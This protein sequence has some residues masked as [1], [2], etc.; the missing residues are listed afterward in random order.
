MSTQ[1]EQIRA[2]VMFRQS[3]RDRNSVTFANACESISLAR[4]Q[5]WSTIS[6]AVDHEARSLFLKPPWTRAFF[7]FRA[8][9]CLFFRSSPVSIEVLHTTFGILFTFVWLFVGQILVASR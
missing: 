8:R 6:S 5:L 2:G 4:K 7:L 1:T 9:N 3:D